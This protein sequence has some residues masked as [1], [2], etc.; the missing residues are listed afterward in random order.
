M[1]SHHRRLLLCI[2][3]AAL[4]CFAVGIYFANASEITVRVGPGTALQVTIP[5]IAK[6]DL[7]NLISKLFATGDEKA[8][9]NFNAVI[10]KSTS[11]TLV[12]TTD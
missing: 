2:L 10:G 1:N 9:T 8:K 5:N 4:V 6:A 7:V 12:L 11:V 3:L